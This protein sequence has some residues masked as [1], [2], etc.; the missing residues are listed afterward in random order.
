MTRGY[1]SRNI[2]ECFEPTE[3]FERKDL[4]NKVAHFMLKG[5]ELYKRDTIEG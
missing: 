5:E 2:V 1:P 4:R 3:S